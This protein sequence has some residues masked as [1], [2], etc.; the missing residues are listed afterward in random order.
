MSAVL[1]G[2]C[3]CRVLRAL[4][5][6]N[7]FLLAHS[8]N[9]WSYGPQWPEIT[10]EEL[11]MSQ[12]AVD[13][14]AE[15]EYL[16]RELS[17]DDDRGTRTLTYYARIKVFDQR[18]IEAIT[19]S[20][21]I[22][23]WGS[24][25]VKSVQ[26]RITRPDGSVEEIERADVYEEE[27]LRLGGVR[28]RRTSFALPR[29][30]PGTIVDYKYS[31][32]A[33][34]NAWGIL[35]LTRAELP[36]HKLKFRMRYDPRLA[37]SFTCRGFSQESFVRAGS[38]WNELELE[39]L[40]RSSDERFL[41]PHTVTQPWIMVYYVWGSLGK[42]W[43]T[44]F[45]KFFAA[46]LQEF[47]RLK[48]SARNRGIRKKTA[49]LTTGL[50]DPEAQLRA[51]YT[52]CVSE[53]TNIYSPA[54]GLSS[55]ERAKLKEADTPGRVLSLG[56]GK[57]ENINRLFGSMTAA[58]G[59]ETRFAACS[60]RSM[61]FF[62]REIAHYGAMPDFLVAVRIP[63]GDWRFFDPGTPFLNFGQLHWSNEGTTALLANKKA[64][65]F[66]STSTSDARSTMTGRRALF[67]LQ[68]DGSLTGSVHLIYTGHQATAAKNRYGRKTPAERKDAIIE[69]VWEGFP[70]VE[71][72]EVE[73]ENLTNPT[74]PIEIS[75]QVTIPSYGDRTASRLFF[76]PAVFQA[77]Q[78]PVFTKTER[79][80]P[81]YFNFQW[82]E[83]DSVEIKLPEGYE[84]E[85]GHAPVGV[86]DEP[87]LRHLTRLSYDA[88]KRIVHYRRLF[89]L[90]LVILPPEKYPA[91]KQIYD[92][93]HRQ[94][95]HLLTLRRAEPPP[96]STES[97][98][99]E[100]AI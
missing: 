83:E 70:P 15:A 28:S 11:A 2:F 79:E 42:D 8:A 62:T 99:T 72:T 22:E 43:V 41:P 45:W 98:A 71:I 39:N 50:E 69:D 75:F 24:E 88:E 1:L 14:D 67:T 13:P 74:A 59:F 97:S 19:S 64:T 38:G 7:S 20:L 29:V 31:I 56:Y 80:H 12:P 23:T 82:C 93:I 85:E 25:K 86:V 61:A 53:I 73:F 55:R 52:F 10:V 3:R 37:G 58:A 76:Q 94:D 4:I 90:G 27:T 87:A 9:A 49:E 60:D 30:T 35:L 78:T 57:A 54:A 5:V 81:L 32:R 33:R 21:R 100:E 36:T 65:E 96:A 51:I 47:T 91:I 68:P 92:E 44:N 34:H 63:G 6:L 46:D 16:N 26:A 84:L 66:V 48:L 40:P 17:I 77:R 89:Q 18:G 95:H